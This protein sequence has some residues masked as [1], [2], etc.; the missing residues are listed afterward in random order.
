MSDKKFKPTAKMVATLRV[1]LMLEPNE[2]ATNVLLGMEAGVDPT[3]I[4]RWQSSAAFEGFQDWWD[5]EVRKVLKSRLD[6]IWGAMYRAGAKGDTSAAKLFAE[7][8]DPNY[9]PTTK[10]EVEHKL[11]ALK[12]PAGQRERVDERI[13]RFEELRRGSAN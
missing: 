3:T 2:V 12:E 8:F 6:R 1:Y 11:P 9:K 13:S 10:K 5:D 7:R 4:W